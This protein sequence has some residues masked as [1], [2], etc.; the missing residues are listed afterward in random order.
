MT[1]TSK[2]EFV[3]WSTNEDELEYPYFIGGY[4]ASIDGMYIHPY[5]FLLRYSADGLFNKYPIQTDKLLSEIDFKFNEKIYR[6]IDDVD[7]SHDERFEIECKISCLIPKFRSE[8]FSWY[9]KKPFVQ[10]SKMEFENTV[11]MRNYKN[12]LY[13]IID[14]IPMTKTKYNNIQEHILIAVKEFRENLYEYF[15][16]DKIDVNQNIQNICNMH[17]AEAK[18]KA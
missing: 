12:K 10:C 11:I 17:T 5:G 3:R 6:C 18:L 14:K 1:E 2:L 7:L 4:D 9:Q 8:V 16:N 15:N 13:K